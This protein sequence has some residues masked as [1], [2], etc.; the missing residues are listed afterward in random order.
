MVL[1]LLAAVPSSTNYKLQTYDF[2][3]GAGSG[4]STTY[5][6]Q[7]SAGSNGTTLTS[8][9]YTLP[10]GIRSSD[11]VPVPS[12]PTFTNPDSSYD[13][14]K[15]VINPGSFPTDTKYAIAIS[16]D[17]F[18]TTKYVKSD[19]TIG[20]TF[21][22]ANYQTYSAWGSAS[23]IF[24]LGLANSTTY[25]VKVAALQGPNTG[26]GFGPTATAATSAPSV[27]FGLVTS[28]TSTPPFAATFAS[29]PA[30]S[31]VSADATV[32]ATISSNAEQ[33]GEV[34]IKDAN[35]GLTSSTASYTLA[36]ATADLSV[37]NNGYGA[38]AG[39]TSQASGGPMVSASPFNGTSNS[40]G[41]LN[42]SWQRLAS[43]AAPVTTGTVT[44]SLKAKADTTTPAAT[45][46]ADVIT[47]S[48]SLL[49]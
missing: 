45:N 11:T 6:L 19:Q 21:A 13:R 17:N 49:F 22:I 18:V 7:S 15:I 27:T 1:S 30:G 2:G 9:S 28:L 29:L 38:Q 34:L 43:F 46:Y 10:V 42:T 12:A 35:T 8:S 39:S 20:T 24:I 31:V 48:V 32:T 3:N 47:L 37:A 25:K 5:N 26:S 14:L 16:D 41:V 4:S 40:V 36:S 44:F 33:G 23:G